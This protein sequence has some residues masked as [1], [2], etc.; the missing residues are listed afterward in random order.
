MGCPTGFVKLST[1][2]KGQIGLKSLFLS[3]IGG[4]SEGNVATA[5]W[6]MASEAATE[7]FG[8]NLGTLL[9]SGDLICLSGDLGA[10]KTVMARGIGRGWGT[11][12]RVTSPTFTLVNEYPRPA[13]RLI[14]YHLDCYRLAVDG[15]IADEFEVEST[16]LPDFL[17][18]EHVVLIEWAERVA[19]YLPAERL[20]V[21]LADVAATARQV[22]VTA[23]GDR[24]VALLRALSQLL[25]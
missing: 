10:G 19:P 17:I 5:S 14:L 16:G 20:W 24:P 13:D 1:P 21:Q 6:F 23:T 4:M 25:N 8:A 15:E 7:A 22:T 12:I 9:Q 11:P 2:N 3:I 18:S